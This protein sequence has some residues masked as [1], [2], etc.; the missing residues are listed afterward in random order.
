MKILETIWTRLRKIA[1]RLGLE[2]RVDWEVWGK[3]DEELHGLI[4]VGNSNL[5]QADSGDEDIYYQGMVDG[6]EAATR[7]VRDALTRAE[8]GR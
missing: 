4:T 6:Y 2:P 1:I 5:A 8:E 7:T 3:V